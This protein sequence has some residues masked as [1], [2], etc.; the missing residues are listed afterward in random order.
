MVR[1]DN[2]S[3]NRTMSFQVFIS[4]SNR[5]KLFADA[6]CAKLESTGIRCW[7]APRDVPPG[8]EWGAAIIMGI[9][10][11]KVMVLVFS[12]GANDSPQVL[13]EVERAVSK[14]LILLTVR[15]ED[16]LP[17]RSMEYFIKAVHW[18]DA[19]TPPF[20]AHLNALSSTVASL[21][22]RGDVAEKAGRTLPEFKPS[23]RRA[24][25]R[26]PKRLSR[27]A[28]GWALLGLVVLGTFAVGIHWKFWLRS[29]D[30]SASSELSTVDVLKDMA[31]AMKRLAASGGLVSNP[32][33]PADLYHNARILAQRGEV[34]L[35]LASYEQLFKFPILYADP[36]ED[37]MTLATRTYGKDGASTYLNK[38]LKLIM[39]NDLFL[40]A[41]QLLSDKPLQDIEASIN[42][43]SLSYPPT[44]AAFIVSAAPSFEK[45]SFFGT[46]KAVVKSIE[47]VKSASNSGSF[48]EFY[49]D[50]IR[51][52]QRAK[53]ALS[54]LNH[55]AA[56]NWE[57]YT[58]DILF[59]YAFQKKSGSPNVKLEG[60]FSIYDYVDLTKTVELCF[61][62]YTDLLGCLDLRSYSSAANSSSWNITLFTDTKFDTIPKSLLCATALTYRDKRGV[63]Q[64]IDSR[65]LNYMY[66][67]SLL[68]YKSRQ[69][70]REL[71]E[72]QFE[73]FFDECV[74][75]NDAVKKGA[76]N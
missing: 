66:N 12:T 55:I 21:L 76:A 67:P 23:T 50:Q 41:S 15:I 59:S 73:Q 40:F 53:S 10:Q 69:I 57:F 47:L 65:E 68:S 2:V 24:A 27:A 14:G 7:I 17:S 71:K 75:Q 36:V 61:I 9:D 43:G 13:R 35:A 70:D 1:N 64:K 54:Q 32:K 33:T 26:F 42:A 37:M 3:A 74:N 18:L 20:E 22:S 5:D 58:H 28:I 46:R 6:T 39:S 44:L 63:E 31:E 56:V 60:S 45:A 38:K 16:V 11:C 62:S 25:L 51:G 8:D 30:P 19:I 49:I 72:V 34:D 48:L 4:Y 29:G 52:E